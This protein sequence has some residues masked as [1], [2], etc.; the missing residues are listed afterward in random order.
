MKLFNRPRAYTKVYKDNSVEM[1]AETIGDLVT[2]MKSCAINLK[3]QGLSWFT[4]LEYVR[5][6]QPPE[7]DDEME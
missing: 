4:I 3:I 6:A 2:M 7:I 5:E 1:H